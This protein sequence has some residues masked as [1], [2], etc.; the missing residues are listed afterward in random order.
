MISVLNEKR[1][2]KKMLVFSFFRLVMNTELDL[3]FGDIVCRRSSDE[4]NRST[5]TKWSGTRGEGGG[6][7]GG[8]G[9]GI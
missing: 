9:G 2:E 4:Q 1:K 3:F 5:E 8:G 6:R 7:G